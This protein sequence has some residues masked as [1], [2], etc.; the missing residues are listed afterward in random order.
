MDDIKLKLAAESKNDSSTLI[1]WIKLVGQI[2]INMTYTTNILFIID[3]YFFI[4]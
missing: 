2:F 1:C 4:P 3:I